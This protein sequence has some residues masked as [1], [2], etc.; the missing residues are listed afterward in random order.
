MSHNKLYELLATVDAT[1]I[2]ISVYFD[3]QYEITAV[4][5]LPR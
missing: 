2:M 1:G 3:V 4:G 5:D